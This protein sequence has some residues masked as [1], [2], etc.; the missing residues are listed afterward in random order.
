MFTETLYQSYLYLHVYR[1]AVSKLFIFTCLQ[2]R[3]IKV[4]YIYM[5]TEM[6]YQS[7][8]YLHVYRNAV[9]KL[10]I[11]RHIIKIVYN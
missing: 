4:I 3:C 6:L 8:L 11:Y 2:K 10:F 9:L 1:N 7:Y 5:F